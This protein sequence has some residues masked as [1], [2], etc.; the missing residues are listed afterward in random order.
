MKI[1]K[2][3]TYQA[4]DDRFAPLGPLR[5]E[6]PRGACIAHD[7]PGFLTMEIR[8]ADGVEIISAAVML[9]EPEPGHGIGFISQL[10]AKNARA[11]AAS[12]MAIAD[13]IEPP[14]FNS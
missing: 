12:L 6:T 3:K 4:V 9:Y 7:V 5:M 1:E 10:S 2:T 14:A 11:V 13:K 8:D